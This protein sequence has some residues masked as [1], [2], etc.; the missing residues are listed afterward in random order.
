[1]ARAVRIGRIV[2]VASVVLVAAWLLRPTT[3]GGGTT[4]LGT[5][6]VSM[7][8]MFHAGDLAVVRAADGY[9]V[10]DV[11]A[12]RSATLGTTVLHRI[13]ADADGAFT[14]QGDNNSW[15]NPD[16]PP[17]TRSSAGCGWPSRTA[18]RPWPCCVPPSASRHSDRRGR[19]WTGS[20][21]PGGGARLPPR[22]WPRP[23]PPP[24]ARAPPRPPRP[25]RPPPPAG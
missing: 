1:M 23:P 14:T 2:L 24:P 9:V 19:S 8:P 7:Q 25:R 11:V 22:R 6:G 10:G 17:R 12:Y 18:A 3:L 16:T 21:A 20:S 4:Y 15:Q 5:H 13:V